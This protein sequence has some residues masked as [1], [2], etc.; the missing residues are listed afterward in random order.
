MTHLFPAGRHLDAKNMPGSYSAL[1]ML[2]TGEP[3][4]GSYYMLPQYRMA[5]DVRQ[6]CLPHPTNSASQAI[7]LLMGRPRLRC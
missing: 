5:L 2:E 7:W 1:L 4:H 3:F 6:G